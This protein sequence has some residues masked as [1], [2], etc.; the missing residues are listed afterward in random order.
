[1]KI[2]LINVGL[3]QERSLKEGIAIFEKRIRRY[4]SLEIVYLNEPRRNQSEHLQK[5]SEG[6]IILSALAKT[7][8]AVLLDVCG[9]QLDSDG[10]SQFIQQNLNRGIKNLGFIIGGPYGFSGEIY[11]TVTE[12]ISLSTM[13][14]S[15]QMIRLIFMEQLYRAFTIL[16]G[17]PYHHA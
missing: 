12:R 17:E 11:K 15:H 2:T 14:F 9:K 16:R 1:M 5:E 6:K 10:F 3:T 7:D 13:T 8:R 4:I